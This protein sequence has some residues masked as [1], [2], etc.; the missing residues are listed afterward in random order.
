MTVIDGEDPDE[1]DDEAE[2][3]TKTHTRKNKSNLK[4]VQPKLEAHQNRFRKRK[5]TLPMIRIKIV[6]CLIG[7][8]LPRRS[9]FVNTSSPAQSDSVQMMI[10]MIQ[11]RSPF[12]TSISCAVRLLQRQCWRSLSL[13]TS[14]LTGGE[15]RS[16]GSMVRKDYVSAAAAE[17]Q[18]GT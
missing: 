2:R 1:G 15:S 11:A 16:S 17:C 4:R 12:D 9:W 5:A 13:R 3:R 14:G 6:S 10:R 7:G 8:S 18:S